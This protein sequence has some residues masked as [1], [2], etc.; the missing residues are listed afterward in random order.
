MISGLD[1]WP[2]GWSGG[3]AVDLGSPVEVR[4]QPADLAALDVL[5]SDLRAL[6]PVERVWRE[7]ARED[8]RPTVPIERLVRLMVIKQR[9]GWAYETLVREVSDPLHLRRFCRIALSERVPDESTPPHRHRSWRRRRPACWRA[10]RRASVVRRARRAARVHRSA[11]DHRPGGRAPL[12]DRSP[13]YAELA[14]VRLDSDDAPRRSGVLSSQFLIWDRVPVRR[15]R[16]RGA[17]YR[18]VLPCPAD[19]GA[20]VRCPSCRCVRSSIPRSR[21]A[22][23]SPRSTSS[24]TSAS[25]PCS[26]RPPSSS[27]R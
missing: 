12:P 9:S 24:T 17:S 13:T 26:P 16:R 6:E 10:R 3:V 14:V 18:V 27:R 20:P 15:R 23:A 25:T 5:L 8:G 11:L 2:V 19:E 1:A 7:S 4:E 21:S 22:T